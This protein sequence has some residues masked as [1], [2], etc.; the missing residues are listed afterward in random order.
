MLNPSH[1]TATYTGNHRHTINANIH[2]SSEI[3]THD[4]TEAALNAPGT[5]T[6]RGT[7]LPLPLPTDPARQLDPPPVTHAPSGGAR[8][9]PRDAPAPSG[10]A[11]ASP[12]DA[13]EPYGG[14]PAGAPAAT[15]GSR[16]GRGARRP[17]RGPEPVLEDRARAVPRR[18]ASRGVQHRSDLL[19]A[20]AGRAGPSTGGTPSAGAGGRPPSR[21][22]SRAASARLTAP[23]L[24]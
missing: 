17:D 3:R 8:A 10:G 15:Q 22:N 5:V 24:S 13:P 16:G 2:V 18:T 19:A 12:R 14:A 20:A 23:R 4:H 9:S 6:G 21:A 7:M 1:K 11:R